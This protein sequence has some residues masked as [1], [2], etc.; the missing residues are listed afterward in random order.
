MCYNVG[1]MNVCE[2]IIEMMDKGEKDRNRSMFEGAS[3]EDIALTILVSIVILLIVSIVIGF[4]SC[5]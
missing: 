5:P 4:L 1:V 2:K 3:A